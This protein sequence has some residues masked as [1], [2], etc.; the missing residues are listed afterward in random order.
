METDNSVAL[1]Q[2]EKLDTA[3]DDYETKV[4]LSRFSEEHEHESE[5]KPK[6]LLW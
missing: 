3:L 4:G 5:V 1:V 6:D 2:M